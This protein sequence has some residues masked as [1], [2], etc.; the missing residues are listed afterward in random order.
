MK[1][2]EL[3]QALAQGSDVRWFSDGYRV[4]WE[5]LPHGPAITIRYTANGFGGAMEGSEMKDC[6]IKE[7]ST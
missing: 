3:T 4:K 1:L 6:Y 5:N 2:R 7:L